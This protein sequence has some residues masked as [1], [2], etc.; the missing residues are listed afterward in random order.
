MKQRKI[1]L[2]L[3]VLLILFT[4]GFAYSYARIKV[5]FEDNLLLSMTEEAPILKE[6]SGRIGVEESWSAVR[7]KVYCEIL[8]VGMTPDEIETELSR[9][10]DLREMKNGDTQID[11]KD[12]LINYYL[13][14][15]MINY[16]V[17][18]K[19]EHWGASIEHPRIFAP[20]AICE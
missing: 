6:V 14:P 7:E 16:G 15:I 18:G 4:A 1:L 8:H 3:L 2:M 13:G 9:V 11:F 10:G 5:N 12:H 17:S 20:T 19:L